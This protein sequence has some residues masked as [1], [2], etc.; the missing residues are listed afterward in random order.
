MTGKKH[1]QLR[2]FNRS[3]FN[4]LTRLFAGHFFYALV[5]HTGRVTHKSYSTP[6]VAEKQAGYI[7]IPL[8]YGTDTDWFLNVKAAGGCRI[9]IRGATYLAVYPEII[10][11]LLALPNFSACLQKAFIRAEIVQYLRMECPKSGG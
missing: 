2:R 1:L 5:F 9:Q 10:D 6:V 8:P 11:P 7:Y 3:V 4:R